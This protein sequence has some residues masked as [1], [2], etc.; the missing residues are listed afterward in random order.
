M[1]SSRTYAPY[2]PPRSEVADVTD[3]PTSFQPVRIWSAR[4]RIGRLRLLAYSAAAE[5]AGR[6]AAGVRPPGVLRGRHR[7]G[8][9]AAGLSA[10]RDEG[11]RG[12]DALNGEAP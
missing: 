8:D 1:D 6:E 3:V 11:A 10:V 4:G 9:R 12:A 2:A 5:H 7:R